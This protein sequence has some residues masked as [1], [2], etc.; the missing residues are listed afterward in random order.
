[1]NLYT[2]NEDPSLSGSKVLAWTDKHPDRPHWN[3]YLSLH[4]VGKK[5]V[6]LLQNC[7]CSKYIATYDYKHNR[8]HF[9]KAISRYFFTAH[10]RS[11]YDGRL[12]F[13]KCVSVQLSGRGGPV[14]GLCVGGTPSQVW[15]GAPSQV[16]VGRY[17]IPG[18]WWGVPRPRFG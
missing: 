2:G 14:P 7:P 4:M 17:P 8:L 1:M 13:H 15:R 5:P 12:C 10:V 3:Y 9:K 18:L 6:T 11:T 16:W